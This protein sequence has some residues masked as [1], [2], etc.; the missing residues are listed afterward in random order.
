MLHTVL[1]HRLHP[2]Y[3]G[4][5]TV[6][7]KQTFQKVSDE[8]LP[9]K[10]GEM[11]TTDIDYLDVWR[12]RLVH[13]PVCLCLSGALAADRTGSVFCSVWRREWKPCRRAV[14]PRALVC[15]TSTSSNW[16]DY[17]LWPGSRPPSTR[18]YTNIH[19][20]DVYQHYLHPSTICT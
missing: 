10:D 6:S 16:R 3:F 2:R 15:P 19:S 9:M 4:T 20:C 17:W 14:K 13:P 7:V 5:K 11:A 12:V 8:F 1:L 18:Y